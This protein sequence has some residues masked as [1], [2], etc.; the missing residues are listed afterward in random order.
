MIPQNH[1]DTAQEVFD[2]SEI[3]RTHVRPATSN[4]SQHPLFRSTKQPYS[5]K[6]PPGTR[7]V[8]TT[9]IP[10]RLPPIFGE[11]L[12][13]DLKGFEK[14]RD[15][16][17]HPTVPIRRAQAARPGSGPAAEGKSCGEG[18]AAPRRGARPDEGVVEPRIAAHDLSHRLFSDFSSG[19][20]NVPFSGR[21]RVRL[22]L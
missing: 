16:E 19:N 10:A 12:C 2:I 22:E 11:L 6:F 7:G 18:P 4:T 13:N 1:P 17:V 14:G 21:V 5:L 8:S 9:P 3:L 20:K 15:L